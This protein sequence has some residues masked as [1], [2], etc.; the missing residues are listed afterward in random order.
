MRWALRWL[1]FNLRWAL[2]PRRERAAVL[3]I[4]RARRPQRVWCVA[5]AAPLVIGA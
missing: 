3:V 2:M 4:L 5:R 1:E